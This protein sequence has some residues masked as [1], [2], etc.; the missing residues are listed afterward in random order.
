MGEAIVFIINSNSHFGTATHPLPRT[1]LTVS[2]CDFGL[3]RQSH[4]R[5]TLVTIQRPLALQRDAKIYFAVTSS[6]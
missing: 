2:K 4:K 1:V 3:L 5:V 6:T